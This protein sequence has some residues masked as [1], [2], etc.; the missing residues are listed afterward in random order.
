MDYLN[1]IKITTITKTNTYVRIVD[2]R[3]SVRKMEGQLWCVMSAIM[4]LM[5]TLKLKNRNMIKTFT[6]MLDN[7]ELK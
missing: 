2:H 5:T 4:S 1:S 7:R 6:E 3:A